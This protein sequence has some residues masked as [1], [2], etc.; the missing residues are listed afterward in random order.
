MQRE[1][2]YHDA[3]LASL[4]SVDAFEHFLEH[5][6]KDYEER[7]AAALDAL[8]LYYATGC[9]HSKSRRSGYARE[10]MA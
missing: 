7:R 6:Y 5:E 4:R 3:L 10:L 1:Q 9:Q 8:Y 2:L